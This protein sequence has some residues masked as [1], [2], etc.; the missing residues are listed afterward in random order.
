MAVGAAMARSATK[1]GPWRSSSEN[2]PRHCRKHSVRANVA[3]QCDDEN[4]EHV[5]DDDDA[6]PLQKLGIAMSAPDSMVA[7]MTIALIAL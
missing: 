1:L 6:E 4:A 7:K 3:E 5:E 2:S